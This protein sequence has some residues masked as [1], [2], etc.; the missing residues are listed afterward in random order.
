MLGFARGATAS[1]EAALDIAVG[2]ILNK[3]GIDP[4]SLDY[5]DVVL[6]SRLEDLLA[7]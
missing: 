7:E 1:P 5:R 3:Y 2:E 4:G 6:S